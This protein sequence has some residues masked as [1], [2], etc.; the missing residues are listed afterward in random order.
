MKDGSEINPK[1]LLEMLFLQN[2]NFQYFRD[3]SDSASKRQEYKHQVL[4]QEKLAA[5]LLFFFVTQDDGVIQLWPVHLKPLPQTIIETW[6][7]F[8]KQS[9]NPKFGQEGP[10]DLGKYIETANDLIYPAQIDSDNLRSVA[11]KI[12]SIN[13]S[14]SKH[15]KSSSS[16]RQ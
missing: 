9:R 3:I 7:Y 8:C 10:K 12:S 14:I 1:D 11:R 16:S 13:K 4:D 2:F 6:E 15:G 5:L